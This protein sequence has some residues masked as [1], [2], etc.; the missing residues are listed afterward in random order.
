MTRL[1]VVFLP[2]L[3]P[4]RLREVAEAADEAGLE[5]LWLWEDCFFES[6]IASASAALAWTER[7]RLG[8]GLLPVPLRNVAITAMEI[9]TMQ[10][11]FPGRV[12]VGVGHGVQSWMGQV[13][14]RAGSP[15]SLLREHLTALKALLDGQEVTTSGRYVKLDRV[16]LDWPPARRPSC[17][18]VPLG[19]SRCDYRE[20]SP[21]GRSL[22]AVQTWRTCGV[23]A[24]RSNTAERRVGATAVTTSCPTCS[25]PPA[26]V[27][28]TASAPVPAMGFRSR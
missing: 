11:L 10:R 23:L 18:R 12:R 14:A 20:S 13:G 5:E 21:T 2:Q 4:E 25:P 26:R 16:K 22:P 3:A 8:I 9:A 24:P 17:S 1:G 27:R 28:A 7:V 19:L 6:G 15:L